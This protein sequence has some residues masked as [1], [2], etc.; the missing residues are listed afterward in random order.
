M[1]EKKAGN[2]LEAIDT[3][4]DFLNRTLLVQALRPT[5]NEWDTSN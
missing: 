3:G 4:K 1:I 5:I 2:S